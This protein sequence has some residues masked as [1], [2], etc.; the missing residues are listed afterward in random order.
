VKYN[1]NWQVFPQAR[2]I[3]LRYLPAM[4]RTVPAADRGR[5]A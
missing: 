1:W 4:Q 3:V 5:V 2:A